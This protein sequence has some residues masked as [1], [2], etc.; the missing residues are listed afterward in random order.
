MAKPGDWLK[1][2]TEQAT[3]APKTEFSGDL[4]VAKVEKWLAEFGVSYSEL[5]DLPISVID[6]KK[7]RQNQA[8]PVAVLPDHVEEIARELRDGKPM[9]P[10]VGY[11]SGSRVVL[12]DGNHRDAA[13]RKV[14]LPTIRAF[15][16][17]PDTSSETILEMS[18][19]ANVG[20]TEGVELSWRIRQAVNLIAA[21]FDMSRACRRAGVSVKSVTDFRK[22]AQAEERARSL[23]IYG[24]DGAGTMM[25]LKLAVLASDPVFLQA[26]R[27]AIDTKMSFKEVEIFVRDLKACVDEA[28]MIG[29]IGKVAEERKMAE[30][31]RKVL[32]RKSPIRDGRL[33]FI[34]GLG[35]IMHADPGTI[36]RMTLTDKERYDLIRRCNEAGEHIIAI[37]IALET[38]AKEEE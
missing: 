34:T 18:V 33:G 8:R 3:T 26:S 1:Q 14:G 13:H 9:P 25:K 11:K 28:S 17:H 5:M 35:K 12:I 4:D 36:A 38:L 30:K 20:G 32:G 15:V 24:F 21:G 27:V 6:E 22:M 23:R 10:V 19:A 2:S 31:A 16:L 29:V 7:S 37:Q